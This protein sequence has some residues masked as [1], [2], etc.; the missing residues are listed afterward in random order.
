MQSHLVPGKI[1]GLVAGIGLLATFFAM[2]GNLVALWIQRIMIAV[3]TLLV[4]W[5]YH[6]YR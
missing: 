3:G 5:N 6:P 4:I 2:D 1:F